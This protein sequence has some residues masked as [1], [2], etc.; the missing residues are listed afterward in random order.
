[1]TLA[2]LATLKKPGKPIT[3]NLKFS[4]FAKKPPHG[5]FFVFF[6]VNS[7]N[8][9][10][11]ICRNKTGIMYEELLWSDPEPS[12]LDDYQPDYQ[13]PEYEDDYDSFMEEDESFDYERENEL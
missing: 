1:L 10:F 12:P 13:E 6:F 9:L 4:C 7:L 2:I 3:N 8:Y 5:G 11:Y